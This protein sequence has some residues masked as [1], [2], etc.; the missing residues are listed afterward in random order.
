VIDR[1]EA[2]EALRLGVYD[3]ATGQ[4]QALSLFTNVDEIRIPL[5]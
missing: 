4:R 3:L 2:A 5:K 1:P